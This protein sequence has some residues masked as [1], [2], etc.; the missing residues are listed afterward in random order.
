[1]SIDFSNRLVT[2]TVVF[3]A[4]QTISQLEEVANSQQKILIGLVGKIKGLLKYT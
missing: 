3:P 1:M 2:K 4:I